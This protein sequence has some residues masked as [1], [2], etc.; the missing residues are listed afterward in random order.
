MNTHIS[1][2]RLR[3]TALASL[4]ITAWA[5]PT[6][7][8]ASSHGQT[9]TETETFH[10]TFYESQATN[11]C[12]GDTFNQGQGALFDG[13]QLDHVTFFTQSDEAWGTF[14]ETGKVWA[15]DDV[16]G[17]AYSGRATAWGNFNMNRNNSNNA[18]TLSIKLSGSD[19]SVIT[20]HENTVM[21]LNANGQ[22]TV[23]FDKMN[24]TCG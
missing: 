5:S 12:N 22:I 3:F 2:R 21:T 9:V 15:V 23:N 24:L 7:F 11:P 14:T 19:G 6:A 17:V 1:A 20:V 13:T 8:A 16:S 10:G 18:F 4:A